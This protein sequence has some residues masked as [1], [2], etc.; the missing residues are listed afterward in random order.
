V[1]IAEYER[2]GL[3]QRDFA[4]S[5]GVALATLGGWLRRARRGHFLEVRAEGAAKATA[6]GGHYA[7]ELSAGIRVEI[8]RGFESAELGALLAELKGA[9]CL[10]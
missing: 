9:G 4:A 7:V 10:P 3:T 1:I 8:P 5:R 2:S 6:L